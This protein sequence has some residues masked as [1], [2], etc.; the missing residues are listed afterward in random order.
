MSV[1]L[2]GQPRQP[3]NPEG[4]SVQTDSEVAYRLR[5]VIGTGC[6]RALMKDVRIKLNDALPYLYKETA[7]MNPAARTLGRKDVTTA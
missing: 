3:Y 4:V 1:R 6:R 5:P 7:A 2:E